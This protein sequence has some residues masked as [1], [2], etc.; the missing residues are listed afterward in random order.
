MPQ[1]QRE[2]SK[3]NKQEGLGDG[4]K[5]PGKGG[6]NLVHIGCVVGRGWPL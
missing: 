6:W 4:I 2:Q 1:V 3:L 5:I